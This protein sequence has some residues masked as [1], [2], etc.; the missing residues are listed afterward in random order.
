MLYIKEEKIGVSL[1]IQGL[2]DSIGLVGIMGLVGGVQAIEDTKL[3]NVN[4]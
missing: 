2:K 3:I 1:I 4:Q